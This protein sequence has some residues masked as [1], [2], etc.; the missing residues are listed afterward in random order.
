MVSGRLLQVL[1]AVYSTFRI[2]APTH[3]LSDT[4]GSRLLRNML[5]ALQAAIQMA[6]P[7]EPY[8]L[9]HLRYYRYLW[10]V[11]LQNRSTT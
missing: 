8:D 5:C 4:E 3:L 1:E 10:W 7:L 9:A 6:Q 2:I 11:K